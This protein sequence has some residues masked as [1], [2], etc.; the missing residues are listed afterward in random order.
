MADLREAIDAL[1]AAFSGV[2]RPGRIEGCP[3]CIDRKNVD[4]LLRGDP[5]TLNPDE[6]CSYAFS[7]FLTIGSVADYLY[8]LP[9]IL[10]ITATDAGWWPSIEVTG[11]AIRDAEPG[12]WDERQRRGLAEF[13][14]AIVD[15]WIP[16][17]EAYRLD[18]WL[19][20]IAKMNFEVG[21]YLER[22]AKCPEAILAIFEEN[23]D[24]LPHGKLSNPYW[25]P[26]CP[27]HDRIVAWFASDEIARVPYEAY[28]YL[29]GRSDGSS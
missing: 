28:G 25:E 13:L 10:E 7:A 15:A 18:G 9:R 4:V 6:L 24:T 5:R 20:A 12:R 19:C 14:D 2:P 26:P 1:Y 27:S 29:I 16:T 8:F 21:P 11:R 22:I 3:C 23:A 17:E